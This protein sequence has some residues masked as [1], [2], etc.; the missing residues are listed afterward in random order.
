[1]KT[2]LRRAQQ[3]VGL[4]D[5][6]VALA[7]L[8]FGLFSLTGFQTRLVAQGTEAQHRLIASQLADE[9]LNTALVD[10][11]TNTTCYLLPA[12]GACT[13]AGATALAYTTAWKTR[14]MQTLPNATSPTVTQDGATGQLVVRLNWQW[15]TKDG[16]TPSDPRS[17]TVISDPR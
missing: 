8:G 9:L 13:A 7:I 12:S 1:M 16:S 5:G 3:G 11:A 15:T 17:H 4:F 6:L 14:V 10:S 2:S